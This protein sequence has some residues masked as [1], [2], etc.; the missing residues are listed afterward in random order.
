[1]AEPN[2]I[3]DVEPDEALE[4]RLDAQAEADVA[5]GRV[6]PHAQVVAWLKSWGTAKKL[7]RPTSKVP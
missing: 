5:T 7:P 6:V 2:S 3:F 4:A 1:M